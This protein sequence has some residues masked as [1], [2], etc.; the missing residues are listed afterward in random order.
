MSRHHVHGR[1]RCVGLLLLGLLLA[2][3][4]PTL[5]QIRRVEAEVAPQRPTTL[6]C[7]AR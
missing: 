6:A 3:C 2:G 7:S 5:Q 1:L 4:G